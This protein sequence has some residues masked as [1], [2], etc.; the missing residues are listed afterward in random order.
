MARSTHR[1]GFKLIECMDLNARQSEKL[2]ELLQ[3]ASFKLAKSIRSFNNISLLV[4]FR[5]CLS[6]II[7][8]I[9]IGSTIGHRIDYKGVGVLRGQRRTHPAKI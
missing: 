4:A 5:N 3:K 9:Q 1:H 6:K 7:K 8:V 2:T